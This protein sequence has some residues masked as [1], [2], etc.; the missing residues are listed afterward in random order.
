[1]TC[2]ASWH[3]SFRLASL[4]KVG[5]KTYIIDQFS[6]KNL[7]RMQLYVLFLRF[8]TVHM[9]NIHHPYSMMRQ[10]ALHLSW[11][12][13]KQY[14][15]NRTPFIRNLVFLGLLDQ[16]STVWREINW[17]KDQM[18]QKLTTEEKPTKQAPIYN[19]YQNHGI[20]FALMIHIPIILP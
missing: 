17:F 20:Y 19:F 18:S 16:L 2:P 8:L 10:D 4:Q 3:V 15:L 11:T 12:W 1:M 13:F 7:S 9:R 14:C 6:I 5:H